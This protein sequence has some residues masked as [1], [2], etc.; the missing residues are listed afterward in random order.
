MD[1]K[2]T[3]K[4]DE[5]IIKK[6][7]QF[8]KENNIS[9]SKLIEGYLKAL[10]NNDSS[11]DIQISPLVESITGVIAEPDEERKNYNNYLNKKYK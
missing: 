4:L 6:A 11:K 3:L 9:L 2:L 5:S 10:T 8:A 7:K 1:T